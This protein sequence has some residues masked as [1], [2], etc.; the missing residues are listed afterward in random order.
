MHR[1][2]L[3]SLTLF[4]AL[5]WQSFAQI[6]TTALDARLANQR[7]ALQ[8]FE[9][10]YEESTNDPKK[11]AE[12]RGEL[13][14]FRDKLIASVDT[15]TPVLTQYQEALDSLGPAPAE[16]ESDLNN[17]AERR[18]EFETTIAQVDGY[19][20]ESNLLLKQLST[21]IL[22]VSTQRRSLYFSTFFERSSN[23]YIS[24]FWQTT[25]TSF[26]DSLQK[27]WGDLTAWSATPKGVNPVIV[28]I[29]VTICLMGVLILGWFAIPKL[30]YLVNVWTSRSDWPNT[31]LIA[32]IQPVAHALIALGLLVAATGVVYLALAA[33]GWSREMTWL[34]ITKPMVLIAL[35]CA[36]YF[37]F[38]KTSHWNKSGLVGLYGLI[39]FL[40]IIDL[41]LQDY[42][43]VYN[44]ALEATI[45]MS[46]I[47][48]SLIAI[49]SMVYLSFHKKEPNLVA[50]QSTQEKM[51]E[52]GLT[53]Y[54]AITMGVYLVALFTALAGFV[55]LER[56]I[57]YRFALAVFAV[58]AFAYLRQVM[59]TAFN[60][61]SDPTL[62]Q[63]GDEN[64]K[65]NV[66]LFWGRVSTDLILISILFP[67]LLLI[68]G[69]EWDDM[70]EWGFQAYN[71]IT[72]GGF[73]FSLGKVV[74]ALFLFV[75]ILV[76]AR[77]L[78]RFIEK[79]V[80]PHTT[81]DSG[82]ANSVVTIVGYIGVAIAGIVAAAS[83]GLNFQNLALVVGAL[84]VGI[85]FGLQS[86]V[87]NFVSGLILLFE[88]PIK[89]GDWV[90]LSSGEGFVKRISVR[91]TEIET[92]DRSSIIVPNSELIS[93]SVTN[94]TLKDRHGRLIIPV[95]VSYDS[96]PEQVKSIL[97]DVANQNLRILKLPTPVVYFKDF[98]NSSLDFELRV[99][100]WEV[101]EWV[102]ISS[103]LRFA[104]FKAFKENGITIPFPQR[105]LHIVDHKEHH[106]E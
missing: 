40:V 68:A 88:R 2:L 4:M 56:Y 11:L 38:L 71:G 9:V 47:M 78:Q 17:I 52:T 74:Q 102:S 67:I 64:E 5:A 59:M 90:I 19:I 92:F 7:L 6:N 73:T 66:L 81:M 15:V 42:A 8:N 76:V 105:D 25:F 83:L 41:L 103:E 80:I 24:P 46:F 101:S 63:S 100:M 106:H 10:L 21:L 93:S 44:I 86:I 3:I 16:G 43:Q 60:T 62:P 36:L 49:A 57:V 98:G 84:S 96:D 39:I 69:V 94:W 70:R 55:A 48:V 26:Q 87:N 79:R 65:P 28:S 89:V 27:A 45:A 23:L 20:R 13:R 30:I 37:G 51:E 61:L 12:L 85:G 82:A 29:L 14:E 95:G 22:D 53:K 1:S 34:F 50:P 35:S 18:Q 97:L 31:K 91:S 33:L 58:L 75:V 77:L 32:L 72:I 54:A 99:F 104:I